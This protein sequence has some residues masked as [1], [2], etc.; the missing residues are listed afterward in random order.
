MPWAGFAN[1]W[2]LVQNHRPCSRV[3][4]LVALVHALCR[5]HPHEACGN[6][7]QLVLIVR[8]HGFMDMVLIE[9]RR[10]GEH[11]GMHSLASV[12]LT[13]VHFLAVD[14]TLG[15]VEHLLPVLILNW[16]LGVVEVGDVVLVEGTH[17]HTSVVVHG[18]AI[19]RVQ[20]AVRG[21]NRDVKHGLEMGTYLRPQA[22]P[23][24]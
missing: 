10:G 17:P 8:V 5:H 7:S 20:V 12:N 6:D 4:G 3:L 21:C 19:E 23:K 24:R 9:A 2:L 22:S 18:H 11:L 13:P 15:E 1:Q 16:V 14:E